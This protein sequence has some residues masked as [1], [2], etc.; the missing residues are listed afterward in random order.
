MDIL[1]WHSNTSSSLVREGG[2][3]RKRERKRER[4]LHVVYNYFFS[5]EKEEPIIHIYDGR[6]ENKEMS[7]LNN[8]HNST[9]LFM[10][11]WICG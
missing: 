8:I 10:K 5:A 9:I 2:R 11:V 6:G 7:I 1:K 4:G 3:E